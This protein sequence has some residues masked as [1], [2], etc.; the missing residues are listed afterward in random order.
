MRRESI[1]SRCFAGVAALS[2]VGAS[3]AVGG[4]RLDPVVESPRGASLPVVRHEDPIAPLKRRAF[5]GLGLSNDPYSHFARLAELL[6]HEPG[7][8]DVN[9]DGSL[10][11]R[12]VLRGVSVGMPG[13]TGTG[14]RD[15]AI[16]L[17]PRLEAGFVNVNL[18]VDA[19]FH[20]PRW[21]N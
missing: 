9:E 19:M 5:G 8:A 3:M 1:R 15:M 21:G 12:A 2:A 14:G 16:D 20:A 7:A 13:A 6:P 10:S 11:L 17:P 4:V 18:D